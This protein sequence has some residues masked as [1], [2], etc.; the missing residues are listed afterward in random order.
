MSPSANS[1]GSAV[2]VLLG[3]GIESTLLVRDALSDGHVVIPVHVDCGLIWDDCEGLFI[4]RFLS[5]SAA[6]GLQPLRKVHLPLGDLL[7]DHWAVTGIDVPR[8]GAASAEL[9]IPLRNLTLLSFALHRLDD[10]EQP[11][12]ALGTTADN[13]YRDGSREYFDRCEQVLSLGAG[14]AV[15]VIT[16]LI[17]LSKTDVIRRSDSRTLAMSFSCIDPQYHRHCGRCIKCGRRRESFR[18]AGVEDPTMYAG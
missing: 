1:P 4:D 3:G 7:A 11:V 13:C 5:A 10:L 17:G 15:R 6:P 12:L 16:P 2:A 14:R 18:D 9:E 8:A